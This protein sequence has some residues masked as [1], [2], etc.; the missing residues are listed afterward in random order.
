MKRAFIIPLA[1]IIALT[2]NAADGKT[3][4]LD[5]TAPLSDLRFDAETG[6]WSET[7]NEEEMTLDSQ[8]FTFVKGAISDY[9]TWWGFTA[10]NSADN[11]R[12]EDTIKF[13]FSN[14]AQGGIVLAE[15]GTVMT[16]GHGAPVV[17]PS[18]P[19]MVAYYSQYMAPR[20]TDIVFNTGK[21]YEA[22]GVYINLN[23]Y[24]YYCVEEGDGFARAFTEGDRLTL[25]IHGVAEDESEKSVE[26][27][28][29]S[30]DNGSLTICRG[31]KYVDLTPLGEVNELYFTMDSTD[32]GA[33]GPNT[34]L[35]FCL[36]KLTVREIE[37]TGVDDAA[38]EAGI[39]YD[40]A[41][42]MLRA[43]NGAF[44]MVTDAAGV[45]VMSG[46]GS[47]STESLPAG[48]YIAKTAGGNLKFAR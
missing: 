27:D 36:D 15:D 16:D 24:T 13:Q 22:V 39:A 30:Y 26:V 37:T 9:D 44:I 3:V 11:R 29:A 4:T 25:T 2:A 40:A 14:M 1:A 33:W 8:I 6:A 12:P 35:Y 46:E 7:Y 5:L 21:C 10:S 38:V 48:V 28:L 20:P 18:V 43:D 23:S 42:K 31:W 32:T 19:Y 45:T 34:P 47:L 41:S 17:D